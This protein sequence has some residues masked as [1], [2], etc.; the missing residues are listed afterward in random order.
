M[1][2]L[3]GVT[4][5]TLLTNERAGLYR[6]HVDHNALSIDLYTVVPTGHPVAEIP[7]K[8][9]LGTAMGAAILHRA[10]HSGLIPPQDDIFG[11]AS[12]ADCL[13]SHCPT[14]QNGI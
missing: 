8:R 14:G 5:G 7:A 11:E 3:D 12:N 6:R 1:Q 4:L 9:Q 10:H 13:L 2:F